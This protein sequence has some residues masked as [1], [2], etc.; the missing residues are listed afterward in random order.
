M[1][2]FEFSQVKSVF[3]FNY[4]SLS[5]ECRSS[6]VLHVAVRRW[7]CVSTVCCPRLQ[8]LILG[9]EVHGEES[10]GVEPMLDLHAVAHLRAGTLLVLS[11][12]RALA[13]T[14]ASMEF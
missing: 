1:N 6:I 3:C 14:D 4:K 12:H 13:I 11:H 5:S 2:V 10:E 9:L 7:W 8:S